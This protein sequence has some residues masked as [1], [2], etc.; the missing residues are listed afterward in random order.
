M[1]GFEYEKEPIIKRGVSK[2]KWETLTDTVFLLPYSL[3]DSYKPKNII[4]KIIRDSAITI[5][6]F[7]WLIICFPISMPIIL[8]GLI[9][10]IIEM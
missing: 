3:F 10:Q 6:F 4:A 5:I 8:T 7:I 9:F 2:S 1:I